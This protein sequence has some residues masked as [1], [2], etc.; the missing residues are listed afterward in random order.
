ML[1]DARTLGFDAWG[2]E[3]I[4]ALQRDGVT[5]GIATD[6]P[7]RNKSFEVVTSFD[8]LEHLLPADIGKALMEMRR[9]ARSFI[10]IAAASYSHLLDGVEL[11]VGR[12]DPEQWEQLFRS[13]FGPQVVRCD[14]QTEQW[15]CD[16]R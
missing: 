3:P 14:C 9:L 15:V 7:F 12:R 11:H 5:Q 1:N 8:V 2:L 4:E 16:V 10:V 6:V 13:H